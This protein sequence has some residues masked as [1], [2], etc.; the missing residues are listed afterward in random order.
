MLGAEKAR[1]TA[2][3]GDLSSACAEVGV[4]RQESDSL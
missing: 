4:L 1:L 3:V 2:E